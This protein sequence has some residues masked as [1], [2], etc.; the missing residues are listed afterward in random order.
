[1]YIN[2]LHAGKASVEFYTS[3]F[4]ERY[5]LESMPTWDVDDNNYVLTQVVNDNIYTPS[6][7]L[8]EKIQTYKRPAYLHETIDTSLNMRCWLNRNETTWDVD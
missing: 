5:C 3:A 6:W 7:N 1:M 4:S 2:I 8:D